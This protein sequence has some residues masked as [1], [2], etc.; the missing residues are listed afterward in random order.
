MVSSL[1][2]LLVVFRLV[3]VVC[4]FELVPRFLEINDELV[5]DAIIADPDVAL[6]D[7]NKADKLFDDADAVTLEYWVAVMDVTG[8]CF[9]LLDDVFGE[10]GFAVVF[11]N[12]ADETL[13]YGVNVVDASRFCLDLLG[14]VFKSFRNTNVVVGT[15]SEAKFLAA[16]SELGFAVVVN[17][18]AD[19]FTDNIETV[20]LEYWV[21]FVG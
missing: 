7:D 5:T 2:D 6:I 4:S 16:V 13:E 10:L 9:D 14:D 20:T 21:V 11:N 18:A 19:N 12:E 1:F 17:N 3:F 15:D 8:F